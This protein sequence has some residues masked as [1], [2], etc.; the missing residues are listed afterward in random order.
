MAYT[1]EQFTAL[2]D[3]IAQGVLTVEYADKK[4]TYRSL[5][6]MQQILSD[7]KIELGT[8]NHGRRYASHSKGIH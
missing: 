5:A 8:S 7:M 2:Q 1:Q 6:E 3:A 4:V